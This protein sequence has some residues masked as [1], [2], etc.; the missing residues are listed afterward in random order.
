MKTFLIYEPKSLQSFVEKLYLIGRSSR[1]LNFG[2][3]PKCNWESNLTY[4]VMLFGKE[5]CVRFLQ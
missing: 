1:V 5:R 4:I 2:L 3:E